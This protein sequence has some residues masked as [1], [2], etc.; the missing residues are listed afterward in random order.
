MNTWS[1]QKLW[2]IRE[3]KIKKNPADALA[4]KKISIILE[5]I[6]ILK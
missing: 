3:T 5:T 4:E 6:K 1:K 2:N